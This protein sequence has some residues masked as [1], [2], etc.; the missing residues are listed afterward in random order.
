[1]IF[2]RFLII[3]NLNYYSLAKKKKII[4]KSA[5]PRTMAPETQLLTKMFPLL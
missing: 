1:M 2:S 5:F 3:I 4:L